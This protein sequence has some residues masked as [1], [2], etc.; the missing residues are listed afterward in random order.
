MSKFSIKLQYNTETMRRSLI[1]LIAVT[2]IALLVHGYKIGEYLFLIGSFLLLYKV[3]ICKHQVAVTLGFFTVILLLKFLQYEFYM[4]TGYDLG[5]FS[6][7]LYNLSHHGILY[8]SLNGRHGFSGHIW[9]AAFI[10]APLFKLWSHPGSLLIL[11]SLAIALTIPALCAYGRTFKH[12]SMIALL[13]MFNIYLHRVSAFDFHPESLAIPMFFAGV[14]ALEEGKNPGFFLILLLTLTLKEDIAIGWLSLSLYYIISGDRRKALK[15]AVPAIIY[16]AFAL[17]LFLKFVDFAAMRELHYSGD[18]NPFHRIKPVIE[19]F[20][21]FG[22]LPLIRIRETAI[23]SMPL[24]EHLSSA[25]R[26]HYKLKCQYS[27]L[28]IPLSI[29]A[30]LKTEKTFKRKTLTSLVIF[31]VLFSISSRILSTYIDIDKVNLEKARYID[32]LIENFPERAKLCAGNHIIP[33]LATRDGVT[34]FPLINGADFIIIDTTWHDYTPITRD[35]AEILIKRL[36]ESGDYAVKSDSFG[37]LVLK[38]EKDR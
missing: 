14:F 5:I 30:F 4:S 38:N 28:L 18:F 24:L 26:L 29:I 13:L 33:H 35:S 37:V 16:S 36:I 10:L 31:G 32:S 6:N 21:S 25:R 19:F 11:Q 22:F 3:D 20:A 15:I 27:A 2:G 8:D 23:F 17:I 9:P 12:I 34:Q 7:I 1:F